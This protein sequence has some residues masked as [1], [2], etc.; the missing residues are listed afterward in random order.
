MFP[1]F[2]NDQDTGGGSRVLKA[3]DAN[4]QKS[5]KQC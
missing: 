1:N 5:C 4:L 2:N 3:I